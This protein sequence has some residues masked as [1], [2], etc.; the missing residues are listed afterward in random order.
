MIR[1][2]VFSFVIPLVMLFGVSSI[3]NYHE[4][5]NPHSDYLNTSI[6]ETHEPAN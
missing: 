6:V 4:P 2:G 1:K 3:L 5:A